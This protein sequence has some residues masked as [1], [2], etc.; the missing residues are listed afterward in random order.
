MSAVCWFD[1]SF[2]YSDPYADSSWLATLLAQPILSPAA[3]AQKSA[4][5][6]ELLGRIADSA[7]GIER[8]VAVMAAV[9]ESLFKGKERET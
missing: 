4:N 9:T 1:A 7:E 3:A 2:P 6:E 8:S 5:V